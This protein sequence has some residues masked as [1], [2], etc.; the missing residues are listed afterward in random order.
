MTPMS[1]RVV[2]LNGQFVAECEAKISIFDSAL[3][4]GDM[5]YEVTRT[6]RHQP[7]RLREHLQRL[8]HSMTALSI[9]PLLSDDELERITLDVLARNLPT[10]GSDVDWNILHDVS[11]GPASVY[12]SVFLQDEWRPTVVVACYPMA[13][14]MAAMAERY[15]TGIDLVVPEQRSLPHS[16]LDSSVKCRSRVHFQL[17]NLQAD[18]IRPGATAV[19]LDPGGFITEGTSGNVFFVLDGELRTPT[20]R[21]ILP[22]ITRGVVLDIARRLGIP[23]AEC[24]LTQADAVTADEAFVTSTSIGLL[25]ARTFEGRPLGEG[26]IGPVAAR[27]REALWQEISLNFAAQAQAYAERRAKPS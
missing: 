15:E 4:M 7:F 13:E 9:D 19:L 23:T 12:R 25:H 14:K 21:N 26:R 20:T 27:L 16:L 3:Q 1:Q 17:A 11:R 24:D 5:A 22:G 10:E 18:A 8:R 6:V 2:Y